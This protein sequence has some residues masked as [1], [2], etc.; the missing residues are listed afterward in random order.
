MKEEDSIVY[1]KAFQFALKS[2]ALYKHLLNEKE[3]VMSKQFLKSSTSKG[4]NISEALSAHSKKDFAAKM[5]IAAKEARESRFWLNL[6]D[7]SKFI[8]FDYTGYLTDV[9]ELVKMLTS[10]VKTSQ[11]NS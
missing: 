5:S 9:E 7:Q 1:K 2:I 8:D 4:A 6:L 3:Y 11:Q 10:I